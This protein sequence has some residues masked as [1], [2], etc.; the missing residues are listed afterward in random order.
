MIINHM[1]VLM[2]AEVERFHAG[3]LLLHDYHDAKTQEVVD[4]MIALVSNGLFFKYSVAVRD[5]VATS[6]LFSSFS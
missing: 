4:H 6:K 2:Q 1:I 5:V 3:T